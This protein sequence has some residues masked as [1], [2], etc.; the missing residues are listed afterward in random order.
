MPEAPDAELSEW[1]ERV[2][3]PQTV[4]TLSEELGVSEI[5]ARLVCLLGIE[6]ARSADRFLNPKLAHLEDP[7]RLTGL[8]KAVDRLVEAIHKQE[9][10]V[11]IGDYDVDGVTS[12]AF[13]VT[14]LK[15][16]G[17]NAKYLVPRRM[18]EGYGLSHAIVQ[19]ALDEGPPQLLV[20]LDCGTTAVQEVALLRSKGIDVMI[21]DHHRSK[22]GIPA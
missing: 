10:I 17:L 1:R 8:R 22:E 14:V 18:E 13:F 12:T 15:R 21:I 3:C 9:A 19:R 11:I 6:D 7:F 5:L 4:R 2:V 16:L 20:A